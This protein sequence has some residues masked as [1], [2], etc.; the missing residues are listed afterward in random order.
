MGTLFRI[1]LY[2]PGEPEAR[3]A[4]TAA[5]E[6]IEELDQ[7]LSDYRS[8]SELMRACR[9]ASER[10]V[11]VSRDLF[12]V[13]ENAL[14]FSRLSGGAFDITVKPLV[15]LW[16]RA[17]QTKQLPN[18][19]AIA[20]A[21]ERVG[22]RKVLLNPMT[23]SVRL[24]T[25]GVKL[26]LGGIAKGYAADEALK[27]LEEHGIQRA[28]ID[29]GGDLRLGEPPPGKNGWTVTLE[30]AHL[31]DAAA[32]QQFVLHNTAIATSS[33]AYQFV[34]IDGIRYSHI[35]DPATGLGMRDARMVTVLASDA[36][37]ADALATT[38]SVLA[39]E[40]GLELVRKIQGV[41][42]RVVR[43]SGGKREYFASRNFPP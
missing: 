33:D 43:H 3:G 27:T 19:Q 12:L 1:L 21:R 14:H 17:R 26:D 34:E 2:A 15:E 24:R 29:A 32:E 9:K 11:I 39:P 38:L 13:L 22:Y 25:E 41:E 5:F 7:R 20:G 10:P 4:A 16:R 28:L 36:M 40:K 8:D 30:N 18:A 31:A 42:A 6:R 23:R 37:T 35:V